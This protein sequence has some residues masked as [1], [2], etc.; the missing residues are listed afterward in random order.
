MNEPSDVSNFQLKASYWYVTN[1]LKLKKILIIFLVFFNLGIYG[2]VGY[3]VTL[4]LMNENNFKNDLAFLTADL[5]DYPY[6]RQVQKPKD[7]QILEFYS[8]DGRD[9]KYDFTVKIRNPNR[10]YSGETVNL[11]LALGGEVIGSKQSFILPN[12]EKYFTFFGKELASGSPE[13][14]ISKVSW[15]RVTKIRFEEFSAPRLR[16]EVSDIEYKPATDSSLKG[17][18]PVSTLNFKIKNNTGYSYWQV[19]I[20]MI[21][22]SAQRVVGVNYLTLE[23][24]LSGQ[25]REVEMRWYENLPSVNQFEII[26]EID[27]LNPGIYMSVR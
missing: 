26:P 14:R 13:I 1:K 11:D 27:I 3:G 7:L 4:V 22:L 24:F 15:R 6:W 10:D 25:T 12:E 17:K 18:I 23:S 19:G 21:L 8:T 9:R 16:F 2:F 20:N 5:I